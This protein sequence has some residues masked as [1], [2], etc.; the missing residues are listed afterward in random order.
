[1]AQPGSNGIR[2]AG[3]DAVGGDPQHLVLSASC[4]RAQGFEVGALPWDQVDRSTSLPV[5][6]SGDQAG[7]ART[8]AAVAVEEHPRL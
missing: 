8:E 6:Q 7:A 4:G 3:D 5:Q 1:M 2:S